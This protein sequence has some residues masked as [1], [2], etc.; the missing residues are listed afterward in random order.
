MPLARNK[1]CDNWEDHQTIPLAL[2]SKRWVCC[3]SL[4]RTAGLNPPEAMITVSCE[5]CVLS[6]WLRCDGLVQRMPTER[7]VSVCDLETSKMRR[8]WPPSAAESY[9]GTRKMTYGEN[10]G[11]Q[12]GETRSCRYWPVETDGG[13]CTAER[14]T[15]IAYSQCGWEKEINN[16]LKRKQKRK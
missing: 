8:P 4:A 7:G 13:I 6:D 14:C 12:Y 1:K 2:R 3:H 5:F 9:K 15:Y 10:F 11:F 16:G